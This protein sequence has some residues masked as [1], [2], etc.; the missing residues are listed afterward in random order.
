MSSEMHDVGGRTGEKRESSTSPTWSKTRRIGVD[1]FVV[2]QGVFSHSYLN[3]NNK[4]FATPLSSSGINRSWLQQFYTI[5]QLHSGS[6]KRMVVTQRR[7][8]CSW[9]FGFAVPWPVLRISSFDF[10]QA[11]DPQWRGGCQLGA[12]PEPDE[13]GVATLQPHVEWD[14]IC[15]GPKDDK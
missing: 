4:S 3:V 6:I 9:I 10:L 15:L 14:V 12:H 7:D 1:I 2:Q 8:S 5:L 13:W 11:H